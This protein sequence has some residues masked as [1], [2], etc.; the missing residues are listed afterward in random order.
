MTVRI[1]YVGGA[2]VAGPPEAWPRWRADGV[3]EI[4]VGNPLETSFSGHSLYWFY[5]E[6]D[7][8][9]AGSGS[10]YPNGLPPEVI[11]GLDGRQESRPIDGM[12]DIRHDQVKLGWW[13]PGAPRP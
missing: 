8:W 4:W 2:E 7:S 1:R 12:P 3:D 6:G 10:L 9:V 11:F 13:R 5:P